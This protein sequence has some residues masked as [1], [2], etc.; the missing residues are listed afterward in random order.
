[1]TCELWENTHNQNVFIY[2]HATFLECH[3]VIS[4]RFKV[5]VKQNVST[6]LTVK[7]FQFEK[8]AIL[9]M[10]SVQLSSPSWKSQ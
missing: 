10:L 4:S 7:S 3:D 5:F 1:M 2:K 6:K 8:V 9:L